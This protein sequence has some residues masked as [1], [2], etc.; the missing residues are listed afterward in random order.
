MSLLSFHL[1]DRSVADDLYLLSA[2]RFPLSED[3]TLSRFLEPLMLVERP[4][5][6]QEQKQ[7]T[8][9]NPAYPCN[10]ADK[11]LVLPRVIMVGNTT[12]SGPK[13]GF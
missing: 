5:S 3:S 6:Y 2:I 1:P 7:K 11:L 9:D 12:N 8:G 13:N 4:H 10:H